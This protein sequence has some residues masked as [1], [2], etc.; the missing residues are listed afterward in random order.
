MTRLVAL[1]GAFLAVLAASLPAAA[2]PLRREP[3]PRVQRAQPDRPPPLR[4][5]QR[6]GPVEPRPEDAALAPRPPR[7]LTPEERQQLRRDIREHGRDVYRDRPR[8]F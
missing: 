2:Q 4:E 6:R 5:L 1:V 8:R 7:P 3:P